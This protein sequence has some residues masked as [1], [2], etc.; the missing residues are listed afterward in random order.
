KGNPERA[1]QAVKTP[2]SDGSNKQILSQIESNAERFAKAG[3]VFQNQI[4][5]TIP[6]YLYRELTGD[7]KKQVDRITKGG[8]SAAGLWF[9]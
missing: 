9:I 3:S 2:N 4:T 6:S 5:S 1:N 7:E 8:W